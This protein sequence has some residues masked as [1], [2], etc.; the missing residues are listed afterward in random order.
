MILYCDWL[1]HS[2]AREP[3]ALKDHR[4]PEPLFIQSS[5]SRVRGYWS[6]RT[7]SVKRAHRT[8]RDV[9]LG[10]ACGPREF[11]EIGVNGARDIWWSRRLRGPDVYASLPEL[12]AISSGDIGVDEVASSHPGDP[13]DCGIHPVESSTHT[14]QNSKVLEKSKRRPLSFSITDRRS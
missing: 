4:A 10:T 8:A 3:I 13:R 12:R 5:R 6:P 14:R 2:D 7:R 11:L 1:P 9:T